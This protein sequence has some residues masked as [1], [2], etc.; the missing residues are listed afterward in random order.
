MPDAPHPETTPAAV[1]AAIAL[2]ES[3][4]GSL[5]DAVVEAALQ[6]LRRQLAALQGTVGVQRRLV[7]ILFVDLAQSTELVHRLDPEDS[8]LVV[9]GLLQQAADCV[10]RHGGRVLR[11]TG[12]G[13]KA[14]FGCD[15][16]H[17]DD[18]EHA[19]RAGLDILACART[20]AEQLRAGH[21]I[22]ALALRVGAH[23]GTVAL[24]VGVEDADT[25]SGEA[26]HLAARM[27]QHAP[28]DGFRV[29]AETWAHVR[30]RFVGEL[31]PP[32]RVKGKDQALAT[33]LVTGFKGTVSED[34]AS[35]PATPLIGRAVELERLL[36]LLR[37]PAVPPRA[38]IGVGADEEDDAAPML[39]VLGEAGM[40]KSRLLREA[41]A[42][43]R[44]QG[45]LDDRR[46]LQARAQADGR[47][48]AFGLLR[49]LLMSWCG[50]ADDDPAALARARLVTRLAPDF[51]SDAELQAA[52]VG[53]LIGLDFSDVATLQT[54]DAR[55]RQDRALAVLQHWLQGSAVQAPAL[56]VLEDLHWADDASLAWLR[57]LAA[58]R[59]PRVWASA[60]PAMLDGDGIEG[61]DGWPAPSRLRLPAL[62]RDAAQS[63]AHALLAD[64]EQASA[65]ALVEVLVDR[66]EG[67]PYYMEEV[68]RRLC[69]D[70]VLQACGT[71]WR[72]DA[73]RLQSLQLPTTL[74]GLLQARLDAL[75]SPLRQAACA[76]SIVGP[77]FWDEALAAV[78][79]SAP[80]ALNELLRRRWIHAEPSAFADST[81]Y[82]FDHHLLH[83]VIYDTVPR[84]QRRQAHAKVARWLLQR[85]AER[86][87]EFLATAGEHAERADD[88]ALALD[89]HERAADEARLRSAN[90]LALASLERALVQHARLAGAD[91]GRRSRLLQDLVEVCDLTGERTLQQRALDELAHW[92]AAHPDPVV[93]AGHAISSA[94]LA[95][96]MGDEEAAV[97]WARRAVELAEQ[98]GPGADADAALAHAE[99]CW[100]YGLRGER[101]RARE[102]LRLGAAF[103]ERVRSS[104]PEEALKLLMMAGI[105]ELRA[106]NLMSALRLLDDARQQAEAS[107]SKRTLT[108]VL[109]FLAEV[110]LRLGQ[111]EAAL[112][113]ALRFADVARELGAAPRVGHAR[114]KESEAARMLG[115]VAQAVEAAREGLRSALA[116]GGRQ[117]A[118][119]AWEQL[120]EALQL[121]GDRAQARDAVAQAE[122]VAATLSTG[123]ALALE[124]AAVGA[125]MD[126]ER[127]ELG[128]A[129]ATV[130]QVWQVLEA[131]VEFEQISQ[132]IHARWACCQVFTALADARAAPLRAV[133]RDE[134]R[135]VAAALQADGGDG[136]ALLQAVPIYRAIL[137]A[138]SA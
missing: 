105:V 27:E 24:G 8:L 85:T 31:Q 96:R 82:R 11:F 4:R 54:L 57:G 134:V 23:T 137:A 133:L 111:F 59:G 76:A 81:A 65:A 90:R 88:A 109:D 36:A 84:A 30:G 112:A 104:K 114:I 15:R 115:H 14:G 2:L 99:L 29:S 108:G 106:G 21:G 100:V 79:E 128:A 6:P 34:A 12:D 58:D 119:A 130:E 28:V 125:R 87:P 39:L 69:D 70:G 37:P 126:V 138:A 120:G 113:H 62:G 63:L 102:H 38:T 56:L 74:I 121:Q 46:V 66:A 60:R 3:Q 80:K 9:G 78:D 124:M 89:C 10:R 129:R 95:D 48:Q 93:L 26:V 67:N 72:V 97:S 83:Q 22:D 53:Q 33:V 25:V 118:A 110:Y 101:E 75:P 92:L 20:A 5:G 42:L 32:L 1:E 73:A 123:E 43:A 94:L 52:L 18:A 7:T 45:L 132:E 13:L 117:S 136:D 122:A 44:R 35:T 131:G 49:Q 71:R 98:A 55:A 107:D 86:A 127:G 91:P 68:W 50:V 41:L 64:V 16:V 77:V 51:G 103:A 40:G 19:L 17:E 47:L 135:A 116:S 61:D